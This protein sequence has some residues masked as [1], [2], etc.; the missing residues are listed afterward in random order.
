MWPVFK[1]L[2][3]TSDKLLYA[4][5]C[6][7][8][9]YVPVWLCASNEY[10]ASQLRWFMASYSPV[11]SCIFMIRCS[12]AF[13]VVDAVWLPKLSPASPANVDST[14]FFVA[15]SW[16]LTGSTTFVNLYRSCIDTSPNCEIL[17]ISVWIHFLCTTDWSVKFCN[18]SGRLCIYLPFMSR[19][20]VNVYNPLTSMALLPPPSC[21]PTYQTIQFLLT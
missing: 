13:I 3:D 20:F 2:T 17:A 19:S 4:W 11:A 16:A 7:S 6:T 5:L 9:A 15:T 10:R 12:L 14:Q 18:E 1:P 21:S 8:N